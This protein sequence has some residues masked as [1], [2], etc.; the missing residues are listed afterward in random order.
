M[1][2]LLADQHP[3]PSFYLCDTSGFSPRFGSPRNIVS[4]ASGVSE[5]DRVVRI[6]GV[7]YGRRSVAGRLYAP[8]A[9]FKPPIAVSAADAELFANSANAMA[10]KAMLM[11][12]GRVKA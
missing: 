10:L 12:S 8:G 6:D 7:G 4:V 9:H 11:R 3:L 5:D 2:V 1:P